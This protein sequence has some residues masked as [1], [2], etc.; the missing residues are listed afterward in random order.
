[1]GSSSQIFRLKIQKVLKQTPPRHNLAWVLALDPCNWYMPGLD[2][3]DNHE[4]PLKPSWSDCTK[5]KKQAA[6]V[7]TVG[8]P[9]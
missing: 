3:M 2:T 5:H 4:M 8:I 6:F 9:I 7:P 1:M